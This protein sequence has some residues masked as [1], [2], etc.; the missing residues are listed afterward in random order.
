[1][2]KVIFLLLAAAFAGCSKSSPDPTV[3][4]VK[5]SYTSNVS[6]TY[7]ITYTDQ[8][9]LSQTVTFTGTTWSQTITAVEAVGFEEAFFSVNSPASPTAALTGKMTIY[10]NNKEVAESA[11]PLTPG[12]PIQ[13]TLSYL[14]FQ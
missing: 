5:Y 13:G 8:N 4:S 2:K 9:S 3:V 14:V 10:T 6:S 12:G 11:V 1:M 7:S